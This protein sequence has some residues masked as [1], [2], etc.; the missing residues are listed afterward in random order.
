MRKIK[1]GHFLFPFLFCSCS[2][3]LIQT[4]PEALTDSTGVTITCNAA[5]GNKGLMDYTGPVYV[6]LGLITDS[7]I[8]AGYWRHVKFKWG[9][10]NDSALA[11]PV[12]K[13]KWSYYIPNIR[14]FFKVPPEEKILKLAV[15]FRSGNCRD[16]LCKVLRSEDGR[17][18]LIPFGTPQ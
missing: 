17:D 12:G 11:K 2:T 3:P 5:E 1:L 13:N 7:S 15:L 14:Q 10:V 16:T 18:I 4:D 8:S 9:S 6:H